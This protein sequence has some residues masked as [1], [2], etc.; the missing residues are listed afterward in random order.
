MDIQRLP[1]QDNPRARV[2]KV[3]NT[4]MY[5]GCG[6]LLRN[7]TLTHRHKRSLALQHVIEPI[8]TDKLNYAI[9]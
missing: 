3:V 6:D 9:Y 7:T 4:K 8:S 2:K 5:S 1:V